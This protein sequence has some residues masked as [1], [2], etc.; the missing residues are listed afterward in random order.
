MPSQRAGLLKLRLRLAALAQVVAARAQGACQSVCVSASA[1]SRQG[2]GGSRLFQSRHA[3][4]ASSSAPA[5][6]LTSFSLRAQRSAHAQRPNTHLTG[7]AAAA[8]PEAPTPCNRP[9]PVARTSA[10]AVPP[11]NAAHATSVRRNGRRK[12]LRSNPRGKSRPSRCC[13]SL[14]VPGH[15]QADDA[16]GDCRALLQ[17]DLRVLVASLAGHESGADVAAARRHVLVHRVKSGGRGRRLGLGHWRSRSA[18]GAGA[19]SCWP[20]GHVTPGL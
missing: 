6:A 10:R 18:L 12:A 16:A 20:R 14:G 13:A 11:R 3:A 4:Y 9:P 2:A 19:T 15:A 5:L 8:R 1:A 17:A 7:S